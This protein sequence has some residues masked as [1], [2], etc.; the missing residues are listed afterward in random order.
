M[1]NNKPHN[2]EKNELNKSHLIKTS[3]PQ[4]DKRKNKKII[5]KTI[6]SVI[7]CYIYK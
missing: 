1:A 6:A 5:D 2:A 4:K 3:F 7:G